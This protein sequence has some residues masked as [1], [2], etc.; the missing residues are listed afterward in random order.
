MT[1]VRH[2]DATVIAALTPAPLA[3]IAD[4]PVRFTIHDLVCDVGFGAD[5]AARHPERTIVRE[6]VIALPVQ[7]EG[8]DGFYDPFLYCDS[9]EEIS[10]GREMFGW[11]QLD[12]SIW[13]TPPDPFIGVQSGH[14]L[15][16]KVLSKNGPVM[17]ISMLVDDKKEFP[18][19]VPAF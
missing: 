17:D 10:V 19:S 16:G 12:S 3:P 2:C 8:V 13:L 14:R 6:A 5:F 15:S 1:V 9:A 7:F 11:P 18:R 4:A